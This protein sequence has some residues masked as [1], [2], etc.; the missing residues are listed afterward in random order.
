M[1]WFVIIETRT[2]AISSA[3]RLLANCNHIKGSASITSFSRATNLNTC[4][5]IQ[6]SKPWKNLLSI[7][8]G[9]S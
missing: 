8:E 4:C 2:F 1:N 5:S 3:Q 7:E 6:A 9:R